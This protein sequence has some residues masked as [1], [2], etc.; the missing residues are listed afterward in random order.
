MGLKLSKQFKLNKNHRC[1]NLL[2]KHTGV[3]WRAE[4]QHSWRSVLDVRGRTLGHGVTRAGAQGRV[5]VKW[6]DGRSEG[7]A[8]QSEKVLGPGHGHDGES[9]E[10]C[11]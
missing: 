2:I 11:D 7:A 10:V 1:F 3:M 9:A 8:P 4:D 6:S 5:E